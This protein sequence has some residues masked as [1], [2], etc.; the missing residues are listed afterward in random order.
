MSRWE[1]RVVFWPAGST[2]D[3]R[4]GTIPRST[5]EA[6]HTEAKAIA[7]DGGTAEVRYVTPNGKH[8][9]VAT[10]HPTRPARGDPFARLRERLD[11]APARLLA[12]LAA[13]VLLAGGVT[14]ALRATTRTNSGAYPNVG[15]HPR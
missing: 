9:V 6:A 10:Y 13:I 1:Y 11:H 8:Q 14:W 3:Q 4:P 15:G 2:P 12:A 7:D 5:L